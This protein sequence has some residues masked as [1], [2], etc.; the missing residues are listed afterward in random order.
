MTYQQLQLLCKWHHSWQCCGNQWNPSFLHARRHDADKTYNKQQ[1]LH[2][3]SV[4]YYYNFT[5]SKCHYDWRGR[6]ISDS[7]DSEWTAVCL[8]KWEIGNTDQ[9]WQ[10]HN[11]LLRKN[12]ESADFVKHLLVIY[13]WLICTFAG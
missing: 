11:A 4:K 3:W 12:N 6:P 10:W 9:L 7:V 1:M 8:F 13:A 2:S 5:D